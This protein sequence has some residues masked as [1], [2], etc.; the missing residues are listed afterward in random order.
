M[1]MLR[2]LTLALKGL[3]SA[4]LFLLLQVFSSGSTV[5]VCTTIGRMKGSNSMLRYAS[6]QSV[7][8]F[9]IACV[10]V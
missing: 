3:N 7:V 9:S 4:P 8:C 2:G 1:N 10:M 6:S 5:R